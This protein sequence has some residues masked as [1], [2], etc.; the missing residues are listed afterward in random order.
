MLSTGLMIEASVNEG[1]VQPLLGS[2]CYYRL[3]FGGKA[4]MKP[5]RYNPMTKNNKK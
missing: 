4:N 5:A 2:F 1:Y 3:N